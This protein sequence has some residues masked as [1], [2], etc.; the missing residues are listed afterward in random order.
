MKDNPGQNDPLIQ[1]PR[2]ASAMPLRG[3]F[4]R[5]AN[6]R[7][8]DP[9][10]KRVGKYWQI[11]PWIDVFK[12]GKLQRKQQRVKLGVV[13]LSEKEA[14]RLAA[15][16]LRPLNQGLESI[17]AATL[18]GSYVEGD[19]TSAVLPLYAST[20]RS[21]YECHLLK[22][23]LPVFREHSLRSMSAMTL[24]KYFNALTC[25][26]ATMLKLKDVLGSVFGSAVRYGLLLRSPMEGVQ[27]PNPKVGK[28]Q[29]PYV[30]PLQF[31]ALLECMQEP[32]TTMVYVCVFAGLRVSELVGLRWEDVHDGAL[33]IDERFCRGDWSCPKTSGSSATIGVDQR[34][35]DRIQSLK[36]IEVTINW[37][38]KG[39]KK[40]IKLVRS[41]GPRDL[42]FQSMRKAG[43]MSDH[44]ILSRHIKPAGRAIGCEFVNWQVLRRSYITWMIQAGADPKAVQAQARHSRSSTTMD[45]YAQFVPENQQ[46]AVAQMMTMFDQ[47]SSRAVQ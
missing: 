33:T 44:N 26:R 46:R 4:E 17:G 38:G 34:V 42:V 15:E 45:I 1:S 3:D 37:G 14:K 30:T 8:Q 31:A 12:D 16:Y 22:Y 24:Q 25:N 47:K 10:P 19:Y 32:Y 18:F 5:M 11:R 41:E 43:E 6:R 28:R 29:K 40:K 27:L 13:T 7:F 23:L 9:P 20:T 36:G 35:T 2:K 21:A 39:A